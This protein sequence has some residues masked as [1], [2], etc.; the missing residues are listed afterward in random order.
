MGTYAINL[1]KSTSDRQG[2]F[3]GLVAATLDPDYF[4]TLLS[5][6]NYEPD[7][8]TSL[9]HADGTL[10][11]IVPDQKIGSG[12]KL[13]KPNSM[14]SRHMASSQTATI[15]TG[16]I[17][18]T[19]EERIA[20]R[21]TVRLTGVA[22][23]QPLVIAVTRNL[24]AIFSAWH[25]EV[26]RQAGWFLF[27]ML[28]SGGGLIL[29]QKR[30]RKFA[31]IEALREQESVRYQSILKTASDGIHVVDKDGVLIEANDAFLNML[32]YGSAAI[33]MLQ[34]QDWDV[35]DSWAAIQERIGDLIARQGNQVFETRHRRSDGVILDVEINASGI[36][37]NGT[38][39]LYA[40]SRDITK[41]KQMEEELRQLAFY[42]TLTNL[43]NRRLL[44]ERLKQTL[45][46]TRRN[47][48][49][50]ALMFLDLDKFKILNDVYGHEMG[51][52]LLIEVARRIGGCLRESDTIARFGGDEFVV[53]LSELDTDRAT[54]VA[55]A[56]AIAEKIRLCL[57]EPYFLTLD[58]ETQDVVHHCTSSIGIVLFN[59]FA[60]TVNELVKAADSAMYQA[61]EDGR[62]LIRFH[63][64]ETQVDIAQT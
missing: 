1:E 30:Q 53:M 26:V 31:H 14:F 23:D 48:R 55:Q 18:A 44:I 32:G 49:Y 13:E 64:P 20:A 42:D 15:M 59:G 8:W 36:E 10:F 60:L 35:Q 34:I 11:L 3:A 56:E 62:N 6:V 54:S 39:Y 40:S 28:F 33:G 58:K 63:E 50:G 4:T 47:N 37:I 12:N 52:L 43:P 16:R 57:A 46:T 17:L 29:I 7:M 24:A 41:R 5:S 38:G 25:D 2:R 19:G 22:M 45:L 27:L 61:K 51:D 21:R 9:V